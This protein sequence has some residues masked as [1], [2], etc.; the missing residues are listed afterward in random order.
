[1]PLSASL[2]RIKKIKRFCIELKGMVK[3]IAVS[4]I[5]Y[6]ES[7]NRIVLIKAVNG[8]VIQY[9]GKLDDLET[10]DKFLNFIRPHQ[11]F[12]V[13]IL[14]INYIDKNQRSIVLNN[15]NSSPIR[16]QI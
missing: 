12:F 13:N 8:S 11:S 15:K 4:D 10:Q 1:M 9:Y 2:P 6:F 5:V 14:H 7:K 3:E 16:E